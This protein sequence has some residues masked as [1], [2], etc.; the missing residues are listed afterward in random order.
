[1]CCA[2]AD[3][4]ADANA[5]LQRD[6]HQGS[7]LANVRSEAQ[8]RAGTTVCLASGQH[9]KCKKRVR[10]FRNGFFPQVDQRSMRRIRE[11]VTGGGQRAMGTVVQ[12]SAPLFSLNPS[13]Q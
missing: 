4:G 6:L 1:M 11:D 2:V 10:E 12:P 3:V 9:T 8:I 7:N 5:G 13:R